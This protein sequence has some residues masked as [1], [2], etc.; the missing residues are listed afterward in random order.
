MSADAKHT[1]EPLSIG[2]ANVH[3]TDAGRCF[4]VEIA[5]SRGILIAHS[6]GL[7]KVESMERARRIVACVNACAGLSIDLLEC[8]TIDEAAETIV[9]QRDELAAA[10]LELLRLKAIKERKEAGHMVSGEELAEYQKNKEAAW[11]ALRTAIAK[12]SA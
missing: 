6:Y 11:V 12:V 10:A 9:D 4:R 8:K 5:D 2:L 7:T 3:H 1:P